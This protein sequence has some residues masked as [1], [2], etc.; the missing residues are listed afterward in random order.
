MTD[1]VRPVTS[2]LDSPEGKVDNKGQFL[3]RIKITKRGGTKDSHFRV[4]AAK[5][6]CDNLLSRSVAVYQGLIQHIGV[7]VYGELG[8]LKGDPVKIVQKHTVLQAPQRIPIPLLPKVEEELKR[9]RMALL[10]E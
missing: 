7:G 4:I 10:S 8:L 1:S 3:A 6:T 9:K 5:S 2:K